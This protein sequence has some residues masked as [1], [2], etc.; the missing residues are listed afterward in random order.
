M[1]VDNYLSLSKP[2]NFIF[3]GEK[4]YVKMLQTAYWLKW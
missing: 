4:K 3:I 1:Y 2:Y